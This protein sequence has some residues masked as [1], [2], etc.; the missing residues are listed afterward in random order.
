MTNTI[1]ISYLVHFGSKHCRITSHTLGKVSEYKCTHIESQGLSTS[2]EPPRDDGSCSYHTASYY[3]H[4]MQ[5]PEQFFVPK[6]ALA[7]RALSHPL[8]Y[9]L[10]V[11]EFPPGASTSID[12]CIPSLRVVTSLSSSIYTYL[13]FRIVGLHPT[14]LDL[15]RHAKPARC[16]KKTFTGKT[17]T[18]TSTSGR[19][20]RLRLVLLSSCDWAQE[21]RYQQRVQIS[22]LVE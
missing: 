11:M 13:H 15:R 4:M 9:F 18:F 19:R 14:G 3:C 8:S 12:S 10:W 22:L 16:R 5:V 2:R 6:T 17:F 7:H 1:D 21:I 20:S